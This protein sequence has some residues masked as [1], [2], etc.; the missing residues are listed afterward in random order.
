MR[1]QWHPFR[2]HRGWYE[3]RSPLPSTRALA[4]VLG[5]RNSALGHA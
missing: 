4:S 5:G 1:Q 3:Y 2:G